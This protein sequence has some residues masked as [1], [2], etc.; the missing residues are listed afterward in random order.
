MRKI[1]PPGILGNLLLCLIGAGISV[2]AAQDRRTESEWAKRDGWQRPGEVMDALGI[3]PGSAVADIGAGRGYFTMHLAERVGAQGR[4]FAV[5][6]DKGNLGQLRKRAKR[7]NLKQV[8]AI[9]SAASD[10]RISPE[11]VHAI[12]VVN[13]YHEMRD[14][15]AMLQGMF[16]GL[17]PCGLLGIIDGEA[18]EG[19]PREDYHSRHDIPELLVRTDAER[20]GFRFMAKKPGFRN[21]DGENWYFVIFEKPA[22]PCPAASGN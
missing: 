17:K 10:P 14:F 8:S 18:P 13:A 5:D 6:I 3:G 11:S 15:D 16:R 4:V 9:H 19:R 22:A 2:A 20:N 12:L 1:H 7:E 21:G